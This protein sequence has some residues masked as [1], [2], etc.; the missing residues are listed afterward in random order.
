MLP[1]FIVFSPF[2]PSYSKLSLQ[3]SFRFLTLLWSTG[4]T[5]KSSRGNMGFSYGGT[6]CAIRF[7]WIVYVACC[8]YSTLTVTLSGGYSAKLLNYAVDRYWTEACTETRMVINGQK[9]ES[10]LRC[11][12]AVSLFYIIIHWKETKRRNCWVGSRE[13]KS[14]VIGKL[15][16]GILP[17]DP[18]GVQLR[19]KFVLL[20][21]TY[22]PDNTDVKYSI[23]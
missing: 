15:I 2:I 9:M 22:N 18:S 14:S 16:M 21:S 4:Y 13:T 1:N 10:P 5:S 8:A 3:I 12:V 7:T 11:E 6:M 23:V 19:M 17:V 20:L